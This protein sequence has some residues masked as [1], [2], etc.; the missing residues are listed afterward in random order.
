MNRGVL[1]AVVAA[2][3]LAAVFAADTL[4]AVQKAEKKVDDVAGGCSKR[5]Y[6]FKTVIDDIIKKLKVCCFTNLF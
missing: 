4:A 3:L 1:F 5:T 6:K 2:L